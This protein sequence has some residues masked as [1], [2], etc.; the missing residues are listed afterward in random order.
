MRSLNELG[1]GQMQRLVALFLAGKRGI[2]MRLGC[3][4]AQLRKVLSK[5]R[6][7]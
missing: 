7:Q 1:A 6:P 4:S 5:A 2:H 3:R